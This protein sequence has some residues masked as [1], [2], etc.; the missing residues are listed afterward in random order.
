[1]AK[2]PKL[3]NLEELTESTHQEVR[4]DSFVR[5]A[6]KEGYMTEQELLIG[7]FVYDYLDLNTPMESQDLDADEERRHEKLPEACR[8]AAEQFG[9]T[10]GKAEEL[11]NKSLDIRVR[12]MLLAVNVS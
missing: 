7:R 8:A 6:I 9:I 11:Y 10:P 4:Y 12:Y 3:P 2:P 5:K 1:M